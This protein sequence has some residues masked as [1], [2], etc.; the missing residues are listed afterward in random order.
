MQLVAIMGME[1]PSNFQAE[2]VRDEKV[3]LLRAVRPIHPDDALSH[4]VRGQYSAGVINGMHVPG[5]REE[6]GVAP[7]SLRET[8]VAI[9]VDID[10]W[11]W[12]GTPFYLRTGKRLPK[13]STEI[14]IQF[15]RVPHSPFAGSVPLA[16]GA[17]PEDGIDPNLLILRIQP[18]EGI[19]LRFGA[20][21]PGQAL[22][23]ES[24][25][26]DFM[27]GTAFREQSPDAYERLLL[28]CMLG[29][30]TLF[31][32]EDEVEEAWRFCTAILDG[33]RA[34]PPDRTHS[35]NY[36]AGTWGP[37]EAEAFMARDG[38]AWHVP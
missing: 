33:W 5:Y 10:N 13:R 21:I 19:T 20:K 24:V 17:V 16:A 35:P 15:R 18:D 3:K 27:Y 25:N 1:A 28:D 32:R 36:A 8:Y 34:H 6:P 26:M 11:R 4:S 14:V 7:D 2:M 22:R 38:R 30:P 23:I 29:D 9:K 12:A 31:A 37:E